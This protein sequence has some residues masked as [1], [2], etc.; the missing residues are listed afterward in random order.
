MADF[1]TLGG[2][3]SAKGVK[4]VVLALQIDESRFGLVV[5]FESGTWGENLLDTI[6]EVQ[7]ANN[8]DPTNGTVHRGKPN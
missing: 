8:G 5:N 4:A 3:A 7:S 1:E 6:E 2:Q